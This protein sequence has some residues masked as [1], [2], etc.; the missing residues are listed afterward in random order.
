M[1]ETYN[2]N[3]LLWLIVSNDFH[4]NSFFEYYKGPIQPCKFTIFTLSHVDFFILGV[5]K[6]IETSD[7]KVKSKN[8]FQPSFANNASGRDVIYGRLRTEKMFRYYLLNVLVQLWLLMD[9]KV[10]IGPVSWQQQTTQICLR[11]L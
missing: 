7:N 5:W 6:M 10:K 3:I 8:G 2:C 9:C 1:T 4:L 11:F